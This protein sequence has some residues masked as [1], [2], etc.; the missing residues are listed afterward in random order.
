MAL[1]ED[2]I[3]AINHELNGTNW[4]S[5]ARQAVIDLFGQ[6]A[7]GEAEVERLRA[8]VAELEAVLRG[9]EWVYM[10]WRGTGDTLVVC[11]S[12][13]AKAPKHAPDCALDAAL[14]GEQ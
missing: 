4:P 14:R 10:A 12:C 7:A 9:V 11:P 3:V 13:T 8:R 2:G 5:Q 1:T 6:I